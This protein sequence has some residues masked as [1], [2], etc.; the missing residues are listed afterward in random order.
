MHAE[1]KDNIK[2]CLDFLKNEAICCPNREIVGF[3][4]LKDGKPFAKV[5]KNRAPDPQNY[6][7]V[8]PLEYLD[9]Q[10]TYEFLAVFHSHIYGDSQFSEWDKV[11]SDNCLV[12]FV[13]YS[14][15]EDKFNFYS[16]PDC[17][18]DLANMEVLVN[19]IND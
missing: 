2:T 19:S 8:D 11:T 14:L 16:P 13:V 9:F 10:N 12:P 17:S 4:G 3:L 5:V 6:F 18:V 1:L 15:S 7:A